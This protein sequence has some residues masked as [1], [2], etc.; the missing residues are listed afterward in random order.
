MA[1][2]S[3]GAELA[4][5]GELWERLRELRHERL[6]LEL[7]AFGFGFAVYV[8]FAALLLF[9]VWGRRSRMELIVAAAV[10]T[11]GSGL[12]AEH[13]PGISSGMTYLALYD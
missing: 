8:W 7:V 13:A 3:S 12:L 5:L 6:L 10:P 1:Q 2:G 11:C 4:N 9:H